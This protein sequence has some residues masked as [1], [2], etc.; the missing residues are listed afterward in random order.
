MWAFNLDPATILL[1]LISLQLAWSVKLYYQHQKTDQ[2]NY[3]AH[4]QEG[5]GRDLQAPY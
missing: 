1:N 4:I 2:D 3:T 5:F